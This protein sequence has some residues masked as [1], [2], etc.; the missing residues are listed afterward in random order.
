[1]FL[2]QVD[3]WVRG[4][5]VTHGVRAVGHADRPEAVREPPLRGAGG[6]F[7]ISEERAS[8]RVPGRFGQA[9]KRDAIIHTD[10]TKN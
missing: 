6:E 8:P 5:I 1:M 3:E 2:E 7:T 10:V 9:G 4:V